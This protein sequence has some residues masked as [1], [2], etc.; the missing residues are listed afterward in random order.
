MRKFFIL[1]LLSLSLAG[2]Y[3][4]DKNQNTSKNKIDTSNLTIMDR[5]SNGDTFFEV[6]ATSCNKARGV[7]AGFQEGVAEKYNQSTRA[8]KFLRTELDGNDCR[9]VMDTPS[10]PRRCFAGSVVKNKNGDLLFH[11]YSKGKDGREVDISGA[12]L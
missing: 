10:G 1:T 7:T 3:K 8:I 9:V 12:C 5:S 6:N 11:T 4:E 2:C